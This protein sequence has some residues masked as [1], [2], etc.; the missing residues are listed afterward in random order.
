MH[1]PRL[2]IA[3]THSG[4]G[5]T[6]VTLALCAAWRRR[7]LVVQPFK[8]GPD[9]IDPSYHTLAAG[10]SCRT[11]DTWMLGAAG[12]P[13]AF[14]AGARG[15]DVSLIEGVMGLFDGSAPDCDAGSTAEA[16]ELLRAPV[17]LVID[18]SAMA[19]SAA[20]LVWGFARF[21]PA[22]HLA[23][24]IANRV[25]GPG[26][27]TLLRR[28]VE[29]AGVP[30]L[31]HLEG[32]AALAV[33][34][35]HLGLVP[36]AEHREAARLANVLGERLAG[37]CDLDALLTLARR[38]PAIPP[39]PAPPEA[40]A[41]SVRLAYARDAAFHFYYPENLEQL[42]A[43]G[44]EL[45]P[46]SPLGDGTLPPGT[47]GLYLGGGFPE[48]FAADLAAN[49]PLHA[50]VRA[51][52]GAGLPVYAECGGLMWLAR[53][54]EDLDGR[55]HH[56]VGLLPLGVRLTPRLAAFGYRALLARR[57]TPLLAA[58]Q[59]ARG[60]EFHHS[61]LD[62]AFPEEDRAYHVTDARGGDLGT[63]GYSRGGLCA[64]YVHVHFGSQ[65]SIA[66]RFVA[67]CRL[68]AQNSTTRA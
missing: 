63:E 22:V 19:R 33:P 11:L 39:P 12:L 43:A 32:D 36:T 5:K 26:H 53:Y 35:R 40:A 21:N 9:Y 58:G 68:A 10:R 51:A 3:G 1:A 55:R 56:Q 34:E 48:T 23:G 15:A 13:A 38:A 41:A 29:D 37:S 57:D 6:S 18:A 50:A 49:R 52:H 45:V 8:V 7:G 54:I 60:H 14:A 66:A 62:A 25:G 67:N 16:A 47:A 61:C 4:V 17:V 27:A 2:V 42:T 64:T 30:W 44:A 65:P 46:F 24:V 28:A 20:A 31:G 59:R